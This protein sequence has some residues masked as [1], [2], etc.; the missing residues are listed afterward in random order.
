MIFLFLI[1]FFI[2]FLSFVYLSHRVFLLLIEIVKLK[3]LRRIFE[4]KK[5]FFTIK[6]RVKKS[7]LNKKVKKGRFSSIIHK[8]YN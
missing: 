7:H 4:S 6:Q 8:N 5:R 1:L 2:I 3:K